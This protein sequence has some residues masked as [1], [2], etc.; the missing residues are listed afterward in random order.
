[1][2]RQKVLLVEARDFLLR[3]TEKLEGNQT[4]SSTRKD[5]QFPSEKWEYILS[6][7]LLAEEVPQLS[8]LALLR[9][10]PSKKST[11]SSWH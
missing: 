10:H 11:N 8:L 5:R 3:S 9:I 1:M 2:V 7:G 4:L 6:R